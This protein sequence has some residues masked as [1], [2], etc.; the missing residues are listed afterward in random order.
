[1]KDAETEIRESAAVLVI[2]RLGDPQT[3]LSNGDAL[4]EVSEL[5]MATG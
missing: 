3:L 5:G 1:M 2:D 4:G